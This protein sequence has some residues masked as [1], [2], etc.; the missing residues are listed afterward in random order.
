MNILIAEDNEDSRVMACTLLEKSG[1]QVMSAI[2]GKKALESI[3]DNRP[4]LIITDILMPEMD[5]Y[6]LCRAIKNDPDLEDIPLIFY[7]ATYTSQNDIDLGIL[8]GGSRFLIKP[9][10]PPALIECINE[11]VKENEK[12]NRSPSKT[13]IPSEKVISKMHLEAVGKKLQ[14]KRTELKDVTQIKDVMDDKL[15]QMASEVHQINEAIADFTFAASHDLIEP[16]RK[17]HSFSGRLRDIYGKDLDERQQVYL[18]VIERSSQKLKNNIDG[19]ADFAHITNTV[20]NYETFSLN[21]IF[22][23][24]LAKFAL[25]IRK[26]NAQIK[27]ED[28]HTLTSDKNLTL[29]LFKNLISNGLNFQKDQEPP[30][31]HVTSRL[32]DDNCIEVTIEDSGIGFEEKHIPKIFKPFKQLQKNQISEGSGIGLTICQKVVIRLGGSISVKS[33]PGE[34]ST[35]SVKLPLKPEGNA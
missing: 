7:T 16:L 32:T 22:A 27:I 17:I 28:L 13:S 15:V 25:K 6:E 35:F 4:D 20:L 23:E 31:I 33:A 24:I 26:T 8:M 18:D 30:D 11:V 21:S 29:E 19:L 12:K 34:G 3:K 10:E 2:N 14:Q 1:H 5:G 9:L